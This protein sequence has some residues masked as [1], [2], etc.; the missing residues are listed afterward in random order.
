MA[1]STPDSM[2]Y[3]VLE[4][5]FKDYCVWRMHLH[6][7]GIYIYAFCFSSVSMSGG[8]LVFVFVFVVRVVGL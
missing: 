8:V 5:L 3:I 6:M 2:D 7:I 4:I 1:T